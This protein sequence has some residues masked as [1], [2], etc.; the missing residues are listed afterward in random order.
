[1]I[2]ESTRV[3]REFS[4]CEPSDKTHFGTGAKTMLAW[5]LR[6]SKDFEG[7]LLGLDEAENSWTPILLLIMMSM[8]VACRYIVCLIASLLCLR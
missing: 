8:P 5:M 3:A 1:M 6:L 7:R 4:I 2:A